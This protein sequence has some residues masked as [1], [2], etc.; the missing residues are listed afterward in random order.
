MT[1]ELSAEWERKLASQGMPSELGAD[2]GKEALR[3]QMREQGE[4]NDK[5][6]QIMKALQTY[7]VFREGSI[8]GEHLKI[9]QDIANQ[10]GVSVDNIPQDLVD[11]VGKEIG[12]VDQ[13]AREIA[14][15]LV[16]K[17]PA[18]KNNAADLAREVEGKLYDEYSNMDRAVITE[19]ASRGSRH[20]TR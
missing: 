11:A 17:R 15:V 12:D 9:A 18:L 16:K 4:L 8:H 14:S 1:P 3:E 10:V 5:E 20:L 19:I 7:W 6:D 13:R 2:R